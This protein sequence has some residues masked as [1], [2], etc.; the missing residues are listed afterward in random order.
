MDDFSFF[1]SNEGKPNDPAENEEEKI[2]CECVEES[3]QFTST[4]SIV[5]VRKIRIGIGIGA[6]TRL[7]HSMMNR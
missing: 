4:S 7:I 5:S 2:D 1:F 6:V 3:I